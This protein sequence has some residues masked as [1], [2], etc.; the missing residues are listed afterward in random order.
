M[1]FSSASS[2]SAA[3]TKK[4]K[5]ADQR[6]MSSF[7]PS[8]FFFL[9]FFLYFSTSFSPLTLSSPATLSIFSTNSISLFPSLSP[10]S[11]LYHFWLLGLA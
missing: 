10:H 9:S 7:F 3:P 8:F 11:L 5:V 2:G 6:I 4:D 1:F